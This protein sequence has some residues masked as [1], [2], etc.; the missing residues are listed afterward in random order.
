M[1]LIEGVVVDDGTKHSES[2]F[3]LD[4]DI[5]KNFR[6]YFHTSNA[7]NVIRLYNRMMNLKF[8]K[9]KPILTLS[10]RKSIR[11]DY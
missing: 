11:A 6:I 5:M 1:T 7:Q 8:K 10:H 9:G 3:Q 4:I 2:A